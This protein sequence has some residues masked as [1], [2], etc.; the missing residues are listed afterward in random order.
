MR[1]CV[2]GCWGSEAVGPC[3]AHARVVCGVRLPS[4]GPA[5]TDVGLEARCGVAALR[6]PV[7]GLALGLLRRGDMAGAAHPSLGSLPLLSR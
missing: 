4:L 2:R 1:A 6:L 7:S 5:W 3:A